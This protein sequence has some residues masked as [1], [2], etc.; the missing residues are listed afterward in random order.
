MQSSFSGAEIEILET[1]LKHF[2]CGQRPVQRAMALIDLAKLVRNAHL[3]GAQGGGDRRA[4]QTA[5]GAGITYYSHRKG[6]DFRHPS[7]WAA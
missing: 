4:A 7:S 5:A 2:L 6:M 3:Q 1:L